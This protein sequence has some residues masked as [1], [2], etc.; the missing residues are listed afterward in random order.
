MWIKNRVGSA[1][2]LLVKCAGDKTIVCLP[3][4][5]REMGPMF[6]ND[7]APYLKKMAG[8]G[9]VIKSRT[10]KTTGLGEYKIDKKGRGQ[11]SVQDRDAKDRAGSARER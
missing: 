8:G 2:G 4:P 5:P 6:V 7:V 9:F 11:A 10:I 1:P 3:G